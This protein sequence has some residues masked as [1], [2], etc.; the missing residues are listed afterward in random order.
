MMD[1]RCGICKYWEKLG[2]GWGNFGLCSNPA[3]DG[4]LG[5]SGAISFLMLQTKP[6]TYAN[7]YCNEYKEKG[8]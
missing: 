7:N 1:K 3:N 6:T 4:K 2:D 5:A 8:K